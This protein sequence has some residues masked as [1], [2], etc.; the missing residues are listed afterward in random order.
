MT[1]VK[2]LR[3]HFVII[4]L[5]LPS[6][7]W[8]G[9]SRPPKEE[10]PRS[11]QKERKIVPKYDLETLQKI[12]KR[13]S[14]SKKGKAKTLDQTQPIE[15][16]LCGNGFVEGGEEC[17]N[18]VGNSDTIP[19]ACRTNCRLPVCGDGLRD[20]AF[21]EE[22][23]DGNICEGDRC[24]A[25]C[26][27][28]TPICEG[29]ST[30]ATHFCVTSV[31]DEVDTNPGDGRCVTEEGTCSLRAAVMETNTNLSITDSVVIIPEGRY[32]LTLEGWEPPSS[33][34]PVI[35]E[36]ANDLDIHSPIVL[37]GENPLTT[38]I[39]GG[40]RVRIAE[41][42]RRE[43]RLSNLR[44]ENLTLEHGYDASGGGIL[45]LNDSDVSLV[46]SVMKTNQNDSDGCGSAIHAVDARLTI[47]RSTIRENR[48]SPAI[49]I[50]NGVFS[51]E[52][53]SILFNEGGGLD[54]H[55]DNP[56]RGSGDHR[57]TNS[58]FFG[59]RS[60][61]RGSAINFV[62]SSFGEALV[63]LILQ[64]TT[65]IGNELYSASRWPT[66]PN[67]DVSGFASA[68][69]HLGFSD[70]PWYLRRRDTV[71][72]RESII[73][74]DNN[75]GSWS[76]DSAC[77]LSTPTMAGLEV[78][79]YHWRYHPESF[80]GPPIARCENCLAQCESMFLPLPGPNP[81]RYMDPVMG[82]LV[83]TNEPGRSHV[84]IVEGSPANGR[85]DVESSL[86]CRVATDQ[87]GNPRVNHLGWCDIG[88]VEYR[89]ASD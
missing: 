49:C 50:T 55:V 64:N 5:L 8:A 9:G 38:I 67:Y 72:I 77:L 43:N 25:A 60:T 85:G 22:C 56:P 32:S 6:L 11:T 63:R 42:R 14:K 48:Y 74:E 78:P 62:Q 68:G 13:S 40:D 70:I 44:V 2:R 7:L 33:G 86:A 26:H 80:P 12:Q 82:E 58:T 45:V 23:D 30:N 51:M 10:P 69:V 29:F 52:R 79:L 57:I 53:S 20:D 81:E 16:N 18:G 35:N 19:N 28:H 59:N 4:G 65:I 61:V 39:D 34:V 3:L 89:P 41:V 54:I 88:A 87:L 47:D 76:H 15:P 66:A 71:T 1:V 83:D 31:T 46:N 17:D 75:F 36:R 37:C 84:P 27:H 21:G 73:V 24:D